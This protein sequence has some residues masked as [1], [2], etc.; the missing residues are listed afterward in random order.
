MPYSSMCV[1][2]PFLK[3]MPF[4]LPVMWV[5]RWFDAVFNKRDNIKRQHERL[6]K[7]DDKTVSTYNKELEFVGLGFDLKKNK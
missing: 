4:L 6:N 2:Y 5:V 7:I 3:K 1:K